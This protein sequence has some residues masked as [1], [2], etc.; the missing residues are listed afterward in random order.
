MIEISL[1]KEN[2]AC[3]FRAKGHSGYASIG[4]DIVCASVTTLC[5]TLYE[6]LE[7]AERNKKTKI[8]SSSFEPGN[9]EII[10]TKETETVDVIKGV[11]KHLNSEY[12]EYIKL[13]VGWE[14]S[15]N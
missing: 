4:N 12:P 2:G 10:F 13:K 11:L 15:E 7:L 14:K 6:S 3:L 8:I 5:Y 9:I 1:V